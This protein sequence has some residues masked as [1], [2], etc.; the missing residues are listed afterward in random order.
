[1]Y[2]DERAT[3]V[4]MYESNR[5]KAYH[6]KQRFECALHAGALDTAREAYARRCEY[7]ELA[8]REEPSEIII[9]GTKDVLP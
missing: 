7:E 2:A 5:V 9:L 1:M 4:M 6:E 8:E 3:I